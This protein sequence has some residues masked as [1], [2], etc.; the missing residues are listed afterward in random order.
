M[1]SARWR[2]DPRV[3]LP[4]N[5]ETQIRATLAGAGAF[6]GGAGGREECGAVSLSAIR[7]DHSKPD[8]TGLGRMP[9]G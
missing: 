8:P 7:S 1:T 2:G 4:A 3:A 5:Y 6:S 9:R